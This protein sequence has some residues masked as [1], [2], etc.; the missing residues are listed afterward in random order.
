MAEQYF[1][2]KNINFNS[3][4]FNETVHITLNAEKAGLQRYRISVRPIEGEISLQNNSQ[5]I[6]IEVLDT[7]QK[8]SSFSLNRR[9]PPTL[10]R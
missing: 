7:K 5:D 2:F 3:N 1:F 8:K 4:H 9:T 10:Q 6:F